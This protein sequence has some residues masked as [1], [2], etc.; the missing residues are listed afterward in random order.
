MLGV[1][2]KWVSS[3]TPAT[4]HITHCRAVQHAGCRADPASRR[5]PHAPFL[6][7]TVDAPVDDTRAMSHI[8]PGPCLISHPGHVSYHL[9]YHTQ[10]ICHITSGPPLIPH[11]LSHLLL[12]S[13]SLSCT[14]DMRHQYIA[15]LRA[16]SLAQPIRWG[17]SCA[18]NLLRSTCSNL[19]GALGPYLAG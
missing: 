8:T 5:C 17:M 7:H 18:T 10:A 3:A 6:S 4:S 16:A 15:R 13:R 11:H 2:Q 19:S 1:S 9:S 12:V 14:P